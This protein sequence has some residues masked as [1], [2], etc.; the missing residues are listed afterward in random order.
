MQNENHFTLA[1]EDVLKAG[2][3]DYRTGQELS[4]IS[5]LPYSTVMRLVKG[6]VTD[7]YMIERA[8]DGR[9]KEFKTKPTV[10]NTFA[11]DGGPLKL[12]GMSLDQLITSITHPKSI[13]NNAGYDL[14]GLLVQQGWLNQ[15]KLQGEGLHGGVQPTE[16]RLY[17]R[18]IKKRLEFFLWVVEELYRLGPLWKA[19]G[20]VVDLF[21][22]LDLT[23]YTSNQAMTWH[24]LA[25]TFS[26][27][28]TKVVWSETDDGRM[29]YNDPDFPNYPPPPKE[30]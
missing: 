15:T 6:L 27:R 13:P 23:R 25:L 17:L 5:E 26:E 16:A 12:K 4:A 3:D 22:R 18:L 8:R 29:D 28:S 21:E 14:A 2:L 7:K 1:Q 9:T 11:P 10:A 24:D 30:L 19:D 20:S